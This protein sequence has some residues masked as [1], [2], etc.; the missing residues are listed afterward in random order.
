M[1]VVRPR[2][3]WGT[4]GRTAA[5]SSASSVGARDFMQ[6]VP[7]AG[8]V[9]ESFEGGAAIQRAGWDALASDCGVWVYVVR[10]DGTIVWMNDAAIRGFGT[11]RERAIGA[12]MRALLPESIAAERT[13]LIARCLE[14]NVVLRVHGFVAGEQRICVLRPI[15][16]SAPGQPAH[17]L[18]ISRADVDGKDDGEGVRVQARFHDKGPLEALTQ[19]EIEILTLV[20]RGYTTAQIAKSLHRSVKTIEWHRVSLG[21]KLNVTNRVELARLAIRYGLANA[22]MDSVFIDPGEGKLDGAK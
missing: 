15:P 7:L 19:R 4:S 17:V 11:T 5:S 14:E 6:T 13:Q 3:L 8:L 22:H 10:D 16:R 21:A 18:S 12:Q 2:L 20:G 1:F 9:G